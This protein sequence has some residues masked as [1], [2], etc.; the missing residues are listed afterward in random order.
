MLLWLEIL[1]DK[2]LHD[3][4]TNMKPLSQPSATEFP[5]IS[6]IRFSLVAL[7]LAYT[8]FVIYGSLVPLHYQPH[9]W[10]WALDAF[11]NISYLNLG[12]ASR[13]D[14]VA[15]ILLFIPLAFLWLGTLWHTTNLGWRILATLLVLVSCCSLC[16]AIE[17]TQ[18]FFPPRTVSLNDIYAETLGAMIG[19]TTWWMSG[20]AV[21]RGY[22]NWRTAKGSIDLAQ[23][24][25]YIYLFLLLGYNLLPLD[26][27][28]SPI[29]LFHKWHEGRILLI[30]FIDG[31]ATLAQRF[32][33]LIT[34]ILI[35]VPIG[36]LAQLS[37]E[38]QAR[39]VWFRL[40]ATAAFIEF[41]QVFVYTRVTDT[42]DIVTASLGS[43]MGIWLANLWRN[44]SSSAQ[45][46]KP[47]QDITGLVSG[48]LFWLALV[49]SVFWYPFDFNTNGAFVRSQFAEASHHV[50][51]S[52]YYFGTEYRAATEVFHKIGFFLPLGALLILLI[53]RLHFMASA[54]KKLLALTGITLIAASVEAG[55]LFLPN[56]FADLTDLILETIGG[57]IGIM[58]VLKM[59][60]M[61]HTVS[62]PNAIPAPVTI[63]PAAVNPPRK[64]WLFTSGLVISIALLFLSATHISAVPYN[65]RELIAKDYP[66]VSALMLAC[67]VC[68]VF[69]FPIWAV[70]R[71]ATS[72]HPLLVF[73]RM[74]LIHIGIAWILLRLA[75]PMESIHDIIGA[76]ILNWPWEWEMIA[77]FTALFA[78][79][80][81]L[82]FGA[83]LIVLQCWRQNS[84]ELLW[85]WISILLLFLP[86]SYMIVIQQAA[87][88]NLT[89]LLDGGGTPSAF[90][91][92]I[93]AIFILTL[94][95]TQ[96]A[97][98]LGTAFRS[99]A[100]LAILLGIASFPL[101]YLALHAGFES[102]IVKYNQVFS[103]FQFL[104]SQD[105]A[106]YA[107]PMELLL[108]YGIVHAVM[109]LMITICQLPFFWRA[110]PASTNPPSTHKRRR[111][112]KSRN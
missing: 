95:G 52:L 58:L 102:Y 59:Q 12:I 111:R 38:P 106:H 67:S 40:T 36:V 96:L 97:R 50:L 9:P 51:F 104:L 34:D 105:R 82:A 80:S 112:R 31:Q 54:Q 89:E 3:S 90:L 22:L 107:A 2:I 42:T 76:P 45:S 73:P 93:T 68:W 21:S 87:T 108:R 37:A 33:A 94:A 101:S 41:L 10:Q 49:F 65:I 86:V 24:L 88:D 91:W 17:F 75:I 43:A 83:T 77:R 63:T 110:E 99:G 23:R 14:W 26:L 6:S 8:A 70:T 71:L 100:T 109:L 85:I 44:P 74:I 39:S 92:I 72:R 20:S 5:D 30:P 53:N 66:I 78:V 25:L 11:A 16:V 62:T 64:P 4:S 69:G 1:E 15:N 46:G 60:T 98:A 7:A 103:A 47:T 35:W 84:A 29:E 79:E 57:L 56:K 18:L 61:Q 32:Y 13:A 27:T 19:L 81:T 48:L 28:L 55:Q